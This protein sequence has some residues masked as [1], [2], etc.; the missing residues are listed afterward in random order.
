MRSINN[1]IVLWHIVLIVGI[2]AIIA[3]PVATAHIGSTT[4]TIITE[5]PDQISRQTRSN[6]LNGDAGHIKALKAAVAKPVGHPQEDYYEQRRQYWE[7]RL[8]GRLEHRD[9]YL[10]E[11]S[12]DD[13]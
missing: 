11:Q 13:E 5:Q 7:K 12:G 1:R 10:N 4:A 8:D 6:D 3:I 2:T 9:E